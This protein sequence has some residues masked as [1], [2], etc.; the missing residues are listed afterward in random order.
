MGLKQIKALLDHYACQYN[1]PEFIAEDPI[2]IPHRFSLLQ[3]REIIGLLTAVIA[4]GQRKTIIQSA[5]KIIALMQGQPYRFVLNHHPEELRPLAQFVH[6]T[7]NGTDLLYFVHFLKW[8]YQRHESLETAFSNAISPDDLTVE[9]GLI[10]F[11]RLFFSLAEAPART[12]KHIPTPERNSACKRLNMFLRWMVRRDEAGVD[13]GCWPSIRPAQLV[14]PLDLHVERVARK[15]G[16]LKRRQTD[17]K[18]ALEL[19][20]NLRLLDKN[21]PVRY[22]FALFG[23]G[24][25]SKHNPCLEYF[26]LAIS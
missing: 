23:L 4:W 26:S 6:R 11:H 20:E 13:F 25:T 21:D 12:R 22:D 18:A 3:D 17:W 10:H 2:Q 5:Q 7:F 9:K 14:C 15:L 16:L 8:Y 1:R 24:L 19:T